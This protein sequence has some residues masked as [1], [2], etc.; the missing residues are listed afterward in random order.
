[1][2][3]YAARAVMQDNA[4]YFQT[5]AA[6]CDITRPLLRERH[7]MLVD[8]QE[9]QE[10]K[11]E[12][13]REHLQ[14]DNVA[15]R[16]RTD[17]RAEASWSADAVPPALGPSSARWR[18]DVRAGV[19][20]WVATKHLRRRIRA[21]ED[22]RPPPATTAETSGGDLPARKVLQMTID[23]SDD[24]CFTVEC[25]SLTGVSE[26]KVQVPRDAVYGDI[27]RVL[28]GKTNASFSVVSETGLSLN[29]LRRNFPVHGIPD[30]TEE[31]LATARAGPDEDLPKTHE[32]N[33]K[34]APNT[35]QRKL[36]KQ[37]NRAAN[38]RATRAATRAAL[39]TTASKAAGAPP[40]ATTSKASGAPPATA[41]TTSKA[42]GAPPPFRNEN[43]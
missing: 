42:A 34:R 1:M 24:D 12:R 14:A 37:Q 7:E 9:Q 18:A 33:H 40:P 2:V 26:A 22:P 32:R 25:T 16:V 21:R 30:L 20:A 3:T 41:G 8:L 39:P 11:A 43:Y 38:K 35:A 4:N 36:L 17:S 27:L 23:V 5:T 6:K 29:D 19:S 10:W 28:R 15:K 13:L 31:L